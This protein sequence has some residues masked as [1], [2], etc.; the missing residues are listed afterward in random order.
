MTKPEL[1]TKRLC[2]GCSAKFYDLHKTPIVCP[3]CEAVFVLPKPA[4][5]R[6]QRAAETRLAPVPIVAAPRS[7]PKS[8][9]EGGAASS[10]GDT[11]DGEKESDIGIPLLEELDED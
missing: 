9:P 3:T 11:A 7:V 8:V 5:S 10:A 4:S 6:S 2:T 1:G